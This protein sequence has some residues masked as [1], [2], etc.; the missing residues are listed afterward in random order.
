MVA[1]VTGSF[2]PRDA[3]GRTN[4]LL[5]GVG[6]DEHTA[7]DLTDAIIIASI[8]AKEKSAV[9]L[10][11]PRDLYVTDA[12]GM[13]PNRINALYALRKRA[14]VR[15]GMTGSGAS[16]AAMNDVAAEMEKRLGLPIHGVLKID[17]TGFE[18]VID[19]MGGVDVTVPKDLVDETYPVK[20]GTLGVFSLKAGQ[21]HLDG[22]MALRYA[23]SRHSTSDFDRSARQQQILSALMEKSE[24]RQAFENFRLFDQLR[25]SLH[26]HIEW[27]LP[28]KE[29]LGLAGSLL[30]LHRDRIVTM[31]LNTRT[32]G[33]RTEAAAGGFVRGA[34]AGVASGSVL[35]PSSLSDSIS[36]W[37][38]IRTLAE[39]M[40]SQRDLYLERPAITIVHAPKAR[41][42]A[43]R[44]RNEFLRYGFAVQELAPA[45]DDVQVYSGLRA[46]EGDAPSAGIF[47][48]LSGLPFRW[49]SQGTGILP[50]IR[51][52]LGEDY[53]FMPFQ[54]RLE[55]ENILTSMR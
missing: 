40:F 39:L 8:T 17:F 26:G 24:R 13:G 18:Q 37:G 27:T 4:V 19:A 44:L 55:P 53:R 50:E 21:Q 11:I 12:E 5:L 45:G 29:L 48:K 23:R 6:D 36:D 10:S 16:I 54:L 52:A 38:Q 7:H 47:A 49:R 34:P 30:T 14:H 51:I 35:V 32:G 41:L 33:D 43:Q 28:P 3:D 31:Q 9:L 15:K 2:T 22:K 1:T 46:Q 42:Q 20:E 25:D